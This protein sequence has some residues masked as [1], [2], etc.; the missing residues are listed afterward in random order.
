MRITVRS[1]EGP[2]IWLPLPSGLILNSFVAR[3]AP[4]YLKDQG[5]DVTKEQAVAFVKELNRYRRKH[6]NW[7]LVEVE[8][9]D[10]DHV[11]IKL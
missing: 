1:K 8:S 4:K 11:K 3:L 9:A 2:N 7:V 6:R 5:I 10:G